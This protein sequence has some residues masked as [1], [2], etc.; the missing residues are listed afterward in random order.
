[1]SR[2]GI[3]IPLF[4]SLQPQV[5]F[6]YMRMMYHFGRRYQEHEFFLIARTKSEQFRARNAIV[7]TAL[8]TGMDYLLFLD[9]DHVFSW[10]ETCEHSQYDFLK[11]LLDHKK[12]IVGCLYYH[13]AGD[14]RPVLMKKTGEH[15]YTFLTDD[16]ITGGLQEVDVQGGGVMLIDMKIFNKITPPYFEPEQQS[17]GKNLGTDIQLCKKAKAEGFSVWCD[18]SIVVGHLKQENEVVTHLNRSSFIADNIMKGHI[19]DDWMAENWLKDYREDVL[20]YTGLTVDKI[21]EGAFRYDDISAKE[22]SKEGDLEEYYRSRGVSQICRQ[23]YYH[24][25]KN[26][27]WEG[28]II[29]KQFRQGVRA[30]GLDFGCGTA[31][32]GFELLKM[33]HRMDFV[34][35]EGA[36]GYEFLKWRVNKD[37]YHHRVGWKIEGPYDFVLFLDVIEHLG[38]WEAILDNA[39]GRMKEKSVLIT[40]FFKNMDFRN[41]EHISMNHAAV[42]DFLLSRSVFPKSD[43]IWMK[44]D[45]YMGGAMNVKTERKKKK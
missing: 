13:R 45:N 28:L 2:I 19:A 27:A 33:G 34:D 17:V 12:P 10:Q 14:Y 8:R 44:D 22:F 32:I 30:Y 9:D 25:K 38:D 36:A 20:E 6:D 15:Q 35:V 1:M 21:V 37:G 4:Q 5:A 16:E 41:P 11:K 31:P 7:E 40:N 39:I 26:V 43:M 24:S 42:R 23:M 3:G 29:L 18:T